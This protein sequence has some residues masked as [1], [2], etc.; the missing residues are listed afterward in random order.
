MNTKQLDRMERERKA[1]DAKIEKARKI[2]ADGLQVQKFTHTEAR[3][4]EDRSRWTVRRN[5]GGSAHIAE[6]N[7]KTEAIALAKRIDAIIDSIIA[8]TC[9]DTRT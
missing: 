9:N 3:W 8:D 4:R 7:G 6:C 2:L 5:G 1:L